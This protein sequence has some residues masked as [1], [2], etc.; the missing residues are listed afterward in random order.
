MYPNYYMKCTHIRYFTFSI[1]TNAKT[2]IYLQKK[3]LD[4]R[5]HDL[6]LM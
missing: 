1:T 4:Q 5:H 6:V 2:Y 3:L